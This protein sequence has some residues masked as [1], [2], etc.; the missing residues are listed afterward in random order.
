MSNKN[1]K[2]IMLIIMIVIFLTGCQE[3]NISKE[4]DAKDS[5]QSIYIKKDP[6]CNKELDL[7]YT[8]SNNI[9]YYSMCL[10]EIILK[11][12][13]KEIDLKEKLENDPTIMDEITNKLTITGVAM[14]GDTTIYKD[15]GYSQVAYSDLGN[16]GFTIIKCNAMNSIFDEGQAT[17]QYNKDYYFGDLTLEYEEGYCS[18]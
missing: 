10:T 17:I 13:N 4:K 14:D 2:L 15:F 11:F 5:L 1:T 6:N 7:Y 8:D 16:T 3:K 12:N 9:K 18:N